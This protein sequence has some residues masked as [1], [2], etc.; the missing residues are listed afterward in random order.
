MKE[1]L[2]RLLRLLGKPLEWLII[3]L[4]R[5][6]QLLISPLLPR[7]CRFY[8]SCSQYMIDAVKHR[9]PVIGLLMGIWR[10]MRCNPFCK[11]GYDPV[12]PPEQKGEERQEDARP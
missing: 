6:Y 4:V 12:E 8:P 1:R 11:G 5:V 2:G 3:G 7:T 10:V 9:G